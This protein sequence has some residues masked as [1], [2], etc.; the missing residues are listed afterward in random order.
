LKHPGADIDLCKDFI[1]FRLGQKI[2][3][4]ILGLDTTGSYQK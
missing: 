1:F 3:H 2:A 4:Q